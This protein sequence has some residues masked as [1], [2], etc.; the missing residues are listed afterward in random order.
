[1][2]TRQ[3]ECTRCHWSLYFKINYTLREFPLNR[4]ENERAECHIIVT[5]HDDLDTLQILDEVNI[6]R[7]TFIPCLMADINIST[8]MISFVPPNKPTGLQTRTARSTDVQLVTSCS[9]NMAGSLAA[10][11]RL[12]PCCPL[13]GKDFLQTSASSPSPPSGPC[14][15]VTASERTSS[16]TPSKRSHTHTPLLLFLTLLS[17]SSKFFA[18]VTY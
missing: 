13:P 18:H 9:P 12:C 17:F 2:V 7:I 10:T 5:I 6:Q 3:C 1:M 14:L 8:Q 15:R 4:K 16:T 11:Q